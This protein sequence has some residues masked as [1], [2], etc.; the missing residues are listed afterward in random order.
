MLWPDL[1]YYFFAK[2]DSAIRLTN[3]NTTRRG[4]S[5]SS[6]SQ[7]YWHDYLGRPMMPGHFF[8]LSVKGKRN[9]HCIECTV[10]VHLNV[11]DIEKTE[12]VMALQLHIHFSIKRNLLIENPWRVP[13]GYSMSTAVTFLSVIRFIQ[14]SFLRC[15]RVCSTTSNKLVRE[16]ETACL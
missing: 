10:L 5:T 14:A 4:S 7:W 16:W 11:L 13:T 15:N 1:H 6:R 12:C 2:V 3:W 8:S 9:I